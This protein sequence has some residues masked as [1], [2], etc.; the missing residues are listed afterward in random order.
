MGEKW[1]KSDMICECEY[2]DDLKTCTDFMASVRILRFGECVRL[3]SLGS[4]DSPV[5]EKN[6]LRSLPLWNEARQ[7]AIKSFY[8]ALAIVF[9]CIIYFVA[10]VLLK[11]E[12]LQFLKGFVATRRR[13]RQRGDGI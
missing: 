8:L 9:S 12:E 1:L 13:A 11:S 6:E 4:F 5:G 7:F 3:P 10:Q 2:I